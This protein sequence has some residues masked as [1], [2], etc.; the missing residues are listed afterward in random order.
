MISEYILHKKYMQQNYMLLLT[1]SKRKSSNE[2]LLNMG[3]IVSI[4]GYLLLLFTFYREIS[5]L[6]ATFGGNFREQIYC[7]CLPACCWEELK[8]VF[9]AKDNSTLLANNVFKEVKAGLFRHF[10]GVRDEPRIHRLLSS[11]V[12]GL[13]QQRI[14][15]RMQRN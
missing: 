3:I 8:L 15:A 11:S 4:F 10:V 6:Q 12:V 14:S 13:F 2:Q 7:S 1:C 5:F 9:R